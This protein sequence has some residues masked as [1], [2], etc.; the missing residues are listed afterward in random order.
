MKLKR[1]NNKH[2]IVLI[3]LFLT[4]IYIINFNPFVSK[5][6][7]VIKNEVEDEDIHNI[8]RLF[9]NPSV[10]PETIF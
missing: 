2:I 10:I 8:S 4:S 5:P 6:N 9:P 1:K 7:K 3:L